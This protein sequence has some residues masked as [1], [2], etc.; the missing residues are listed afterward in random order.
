MKTITKEYK[1]YNF[2]E[3]TQEAKDKARNNW[4]KNDDIPFL[5]EDIRDRLS[6]LLE[7]NKITG[8]PR[9]FYSLSYCQGDGVMFEG[10]FEWNGYSLDIKHS[11][12]YYHSYCKTLD[13]TDEE[14]NQPE[15]D[16][17]ELAF[18]SIYQD[19][20]KELE[21][22]GYDVIETAQSE[23]NFKDICEANEYTFLEDGTMFNS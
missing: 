21:K 7:E 2:D 18:E 13:I 12:H 10:Y 3:L 8:E 20:C 14:G 5:L 1:V 19:I 22:Y 17:P 16:E 4:N 11:G 23:E 6:E 9:I 15:T